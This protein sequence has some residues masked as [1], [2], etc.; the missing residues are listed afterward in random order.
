MVKRVL[1]AIGSSD[2]NAG[3]HLWAGELG[4]RFGA[5]VT[6]VPLVDPESWMR[7]APTVIT[8]GHA[9]HLLEEQP[10]EAVSDRLAKLRA[11]CMGAFADSGVSVEFLPAGTR[12]WETL[13][14]ETR[15]HDLLV[16]GL[17]GTFDPVL[18]P[19]FLTSI[20]DLLGRG[21][22]P[23]LAVPGQWR[24]IRGVLAAFSGTVASARALKRFVQLQLWPEAPVEVVCMSNDA[25][26]A[27][28]HLAQAKRYLEAHGRPVSTTAFRG[29]AAD[30]CRF[31]IDHPA[32]LIVAGS[33]HRNRFGIETS[34]EVL[35]GILDQS[36][37]PV[38]IAS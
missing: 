22:C 38:L 25:A 33:S 17:N 26:E 20:G 14:S 11:Q 4:K 19:D 23:V 36:D 13:L 29:T 24:E 21:A 10:W 34:S 37:V 31:A 1:T 3:T 18:V 27:A 6:V 32:E 30:L 2:G 7:P 35:R 28:A 8:S 5:S 9:A 12:P 15:F 16:F